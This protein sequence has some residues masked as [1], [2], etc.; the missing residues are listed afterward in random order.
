MK[1]LR[2]FILDSAPRS[3]LHHILETFG[4]AR[5][6]LAHLSYY[7]TNRAPLAR[8]DDKMSKLLV[9]D[10]DLLQDVILLSYPFAQYVSDLPSLKSALMTMTFRAFPTTY[11]LVTVLRRPVYISTYLNGAD[12]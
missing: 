5:P 6:L 2:W 7:V 11:R 12:V 9:N 4:R 3:F 10:S 1:S 8:L